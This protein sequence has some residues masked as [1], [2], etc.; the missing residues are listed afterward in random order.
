[1]EVLYVE[2]KPATLELAFSGDLTV[3]ESPKASVA[4]APTM[5]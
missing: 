1:V 4:T 2:G 3:T 5:S